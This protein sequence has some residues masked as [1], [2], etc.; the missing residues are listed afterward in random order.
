MGRI[1]QLTMPETTEGAL[2]AVGK[3]YA[4]AEH[5]LVKAPAR[6]RRNVFATSI[7]YLSGALPRWSQDINL[8]GIV[9]CDCEGKIC[10]VIMNDI[11]RPHRK[12]PAGRK[13]V[14]V[15][16]GEAVLHREPQANVVMMA[17][18]GSAVPVL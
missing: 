12:V 9:N 7:G 11:H 5:S 14:E 8:G 15:R 2:I 16:K 10:R 1:Q 6:K 13:P 18:V 17:R 4:F 3:K